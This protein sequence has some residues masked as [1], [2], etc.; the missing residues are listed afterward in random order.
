MNFGF[1][2]FSSLALMTITGIGVLDAADK[3]PPIV[4]VNPS[5]LPKGGIT[6]L[7]SHRFVHYERIRNVAFTPESSSIF[8]QC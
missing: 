4:I 7:G 2:R 5:P 8:V 3:K 1:A 6:R